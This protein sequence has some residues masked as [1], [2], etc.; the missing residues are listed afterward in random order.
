MDNNILVTRSSMPA[1]DEYIEEIRPIWES[2]WLTNMGVKHKQ[3]QA[4]LEEYLDVPHVALYTNGHLALENAIAALNLPEGGEVI[5]TPFTFA[6]TTHAI[7]RNGLV[8]VFCDVND[9]DYTISYDYKSKKE[10]RKM[11]DNES[12]GR[13]FGEL[14]PT[15]QK[16]GM[17]LTQIFEMEKK[18]RKAVEDVEPPKIALIGFTGVGKSSTIN[19]L[20]NAGREISDVKAC[21]KEEAEIYGNI[22]EYTGAKGK[23]IVYDMPGLGEDI[24]A[25]IKNMEIYNR[26][27][28]LV[29]VVVWTFNA[30]DRAMTPMEQAIKTLDKEFGSDFVNKLIF[31]VNKADITAPGESAWNTTINMP[32]KEQMGNITEFE[33]YILEKVKRVLPKWEGTIVTYSAKRRYRLDVLMTNM[34]EA[35]PKERRWVLD[36]VADVADFTEFIDPQYK[37]FVMNQVKK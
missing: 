15:L 10:D 29:D 16:A 24:D 23:V 27:L 33:K 31:A 37:K 32:S 1:L 26:I 13:I 6:S 12:F 30:G 25:D 22:E 3:L 8:P 11:F 7:V 34:I 20:F 35:V 4:E 18:L 14:K 9:R 19:A 21:T 28:P 5:T 36:K 2:H 17:S